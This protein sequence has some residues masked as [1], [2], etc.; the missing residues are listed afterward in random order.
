MNWQ[1]VPHRWTA[2][3]HFPRELCAGC[4]LVRLRNT[5]TRWCESHGCDHD[6]HPGY[7]AAVRDLGRM[8]RANA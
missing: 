5:L 4:G 2:I 3:K 6:E 8:E 1:H 7:R